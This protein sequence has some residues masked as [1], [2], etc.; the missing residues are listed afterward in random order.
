[1]SVKRTIGLIACAALALTLGLGCALYRNDKCYVEDSQYA[2]AREI[3]IRT[4][5]LDLVERQLKEWEWRRCKV[6]ETM[7]RLNKEF[8]VLPEELPVAQAPQQ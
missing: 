2:R 3:F 8:E 4:G 7:Y 1:M 5:S 6:N